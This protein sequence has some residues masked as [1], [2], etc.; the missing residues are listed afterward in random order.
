M[1]RSA[2]A[3]ASTGY[4]VTC[5]PGNIFPVPPPRARFCAVTRVRAHGTSRR[6]GLHAC[7]CPAVAAQACQN[8]MHAALRLH[9]ALRGRAPPRARGG[10]GVAGT[11]S[12]G[13]GGGFS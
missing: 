10:G 2:L 13:G 8:H 4:G 5:E 9:T 6:V 12:G 11:A 7:T 3:D 1:Q